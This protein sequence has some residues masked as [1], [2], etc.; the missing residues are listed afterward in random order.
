MCIQIYSMQTQ[1]CTWEQ[2]LVQF[3]I[4]PVVKQSALWNR[5]RLNAGLLLIEIIHIKSGAKNRVTKIAPKV[6]QRGVLKRNVSRIC[7]GTCTNWT[8]WNTCQPF[9][10]S[11]S[12]NQ[13]LSLR[14]EFPDMRCGRVRRCTLAAEADWCR[15]GGAWTTNSRL[16][17]TTACWHVYSLN[18]RHFYRLGKVSCHKT[19]N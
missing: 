3:Q 18:L 14:A 2:W 10:T 19:I 6:T 5:S 8:L 16:S 7:F 4:L 9:R 11:A 17:K 13:T 1:V 15:R 12:G